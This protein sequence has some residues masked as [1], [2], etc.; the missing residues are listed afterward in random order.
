MEGPSVKKILTPFKNRTAS[1][2]EHRDAGSSRPDMVRQ[3]ERKRSRPTRASLTREREPQL[4]TRI[5]PSSSS[6]ERR[7]ARTPKPEAPRRG[8]MRQRVAPVD[9]GVSDPA[10]SESSRCSSSL[11]PTVRDG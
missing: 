4:T 8:S 5:Q 3:L 7:R 1:Q 9:S 11:P 2:H 6:S 10:S